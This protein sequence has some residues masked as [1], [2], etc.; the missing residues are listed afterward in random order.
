MK[1]ARN[2]AVAGGK[3]LNTVEEYFANP[4]VLRNPDEQRIYQLLVASRWL[5][6]EQLEFNGSCLKETSLCRW[7]HREAA[8][9]RRQRR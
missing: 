8:K 6:E 4:S 7:V 1:N 3:K 5:T 2:R 9:K